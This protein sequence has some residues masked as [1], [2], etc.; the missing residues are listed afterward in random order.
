MATSKGQRLGIWIIALT[1]LLGTIGGFVAMIVAPGNEARDR[2]ALEAAFEQY[3]NS[4]DALGEKHYPEFSKYSSEVAAFDAAAVTELKTRDL[5]VGDGAEIND[6]TKFSAYYILWL[7]SGKI[8][9][10][11]I[12]D[13]KLDKP[14][15]V[16]TG[17]K[18]MALIDGW[19]EGMIGMKIGGVRELTVPSDKGYGKDGK[20]GATEADSIPA[21]TPLKFI[22]MAV[23]SPE[24]P[25]L[26]KKEYEKYGLS[27]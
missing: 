15:A 5:K 23:E 10:Q 17:L 13:G 22:V 27:I 12:K 21:D 19:K 6:N 26:V 14:L 2:A 11:S 8:Q 18:E 9:E 1:M 25:E 7:P 4:L 16:S 20:Q 24:V 3:N